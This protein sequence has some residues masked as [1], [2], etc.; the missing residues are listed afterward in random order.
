M[1]VLQ[2]PVNGIDLYGE[3]TFQIGLS[4]SYTFFGVSGTISIGIVFDGH[5]NVAPYY[6]LGVGAGAGLGGMAGFQFAGS[7]ANTVCNLSKGFGNASVGLGD[8]A[9]SS[10][11]GFWGGSAKAPI[12]GLGAT[13]GAGFGETSF[14][15]ATYTFIGPVGHL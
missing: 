10:V 7:D 2:D 6:V 1:G 9:A 3:W 8:L 4:G 14:D 5:G 12:S 11:D 15:G 13:I